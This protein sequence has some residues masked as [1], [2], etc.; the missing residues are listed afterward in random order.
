MKPTLDPIVSAQLHEGLEVADT[1]I[2]K[3]HAVRNEMRSA[4]SDL[5]KVFNLQFF[6]SVVSIYYYITIYMNFI[7]LC[8]HVPKKNL[9]ATFCF[10]LIITE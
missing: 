10:S 8:L 5:V 7:M 2:D 9:L 3:C 1:E 4:L 6:S